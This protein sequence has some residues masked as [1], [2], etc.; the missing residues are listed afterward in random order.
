MQ[1]FL[2]L[3]YHADFFMGNGGQLERI[4]VPEEKTPGRR[5]DLCCESSGGAEESAC[6]DA[7][8]AQRSMAI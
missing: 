1:H 5:L 8:I 4:T 7:A 3:S 2:R 6:E